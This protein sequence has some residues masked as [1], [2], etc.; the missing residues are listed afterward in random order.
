MTVWQPVCHTVLYC[1]V[2][3]STS[4][5]HVPDI[6]VHAGAVP[7]LYAEAA[8]CCGTGGQTLM[9]GMVRTP[10]VATSA[11]PLGRTPSARWLHSQHVALELP[12]SSG[13][14]SSGSALQLRLWLRGLAA[15]DAAALP[16]LHTA[17][18]ATPAAGDVLLGTAQLGLAAL[19]QLG[20]GGVEGWC[21]LL[22]GGSSPAGQIKV[23]AWLLLALFPGF[24]E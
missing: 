6:A 13:S 21:A 3:L 5:A 8:C 24:M 23:R 10:L 19:P 18:P 12:A 14:S 7:C 16:P 9:S 17:V 22:S 4:S 15:A 11:G 2:L 1:T 20:L